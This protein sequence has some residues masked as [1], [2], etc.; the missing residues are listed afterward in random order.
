MNNNN[1]GQPHS[2]FASNV[3]KP[4]HQNYPA[5]LLKFNAWVT[6]VNN[7]E[8]AVNVILQK[9][10]V[11][12]EPAVVPFKFM[13]SDGVETLELAFG[14]GSADVNHPFI[15]SSITNDIINEAI[16]AGVDENNNPVYKTLEEVLNS[17][18]SKEDAQFVINQGVMD[19]VK[20]ETVINNIAGAVSET[21]VIQEVINKEL[22][23]RSLTELVDKV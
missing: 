4:G 2:P 8:T 13:H 22:K 9:K 3:R 18:I 10:L 21:G 15:K 11:L 7:F 16:I 12:G 1:S 23:W 20:N 6:P 17:L 14:I 5:D 19:A